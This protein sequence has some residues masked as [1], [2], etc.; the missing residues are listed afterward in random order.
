M[1]L[2][3]ITTRG[4]G[5]RGNSPEMELL[6]REIAGRK[7]EIEKLQQQLGEWYYQAHKDAPENDA[8]ALVGQI[9][10]A[11]ARIEEIEQRIAELKGLVRCR[12]CGTMNMRTAAFCNGCGSSLVPE[13]KVQCPT[14]GRFVDAEYLFCIYCGSRIAQEKS[15]QEIMVSAPEPEEEPVHMTF[16]AAIPDVRTCKY[17]GSVLEAEDLFCTECGMKA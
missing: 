2:Q 3:K 12:K 11:E 13:G 6:N 1:A 8:A 17:C 15:A 10:S 14:C 7:E 9:R 4:R 16:A 5:D